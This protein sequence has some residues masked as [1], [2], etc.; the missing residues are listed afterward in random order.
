M[1]NEFAAYTDSKFLITDKNLRA[2]DV[3]DSPG[4]HTAIVIATTNTTTEIPKRI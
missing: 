2:G 4:I 1:Q 3:L